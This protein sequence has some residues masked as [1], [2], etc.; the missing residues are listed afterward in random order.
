MILDKEIIQIINKETA[1]CSS[2]G[3]EL[4]L[5]DKY[6]NYHYYTEKFLQYLT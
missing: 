1:I 4:S 2:V 5:E 3:V 6:S